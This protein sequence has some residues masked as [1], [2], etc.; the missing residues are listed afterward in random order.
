MVGIKC[1]NQVAVIFKP[2]VQ[3]Y[4]QL[5]LFLMN[6]NMQSTAGITPQL[7]II[8]AAALQIAHHPLFLK[9]AQ[10]QEAL[11]RR[12]HQRQ[13]IPTA[14]PRSIYPHA[15]MAHT[16]YRTQLMRKRKERNLN[17]CQACKKRKIGVSSH[18]EFVHINPGP[19]LMTYIYAY[20]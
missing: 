12:T 7:H 8:I 9:P 16:H 6:F 13:A 1:D 2:L 20:I 3:P 4:L 15:H 17:P 11:A 19:L 14:P 5:V 18:A 10:T